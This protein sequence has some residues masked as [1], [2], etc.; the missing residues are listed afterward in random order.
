[1]PAS[2]RE[3]EETWTCTGRNLLKD[4]DLT[5]EEFIYLI[6]LA[7]KLRLEK[8]VGERARQARGPEHRADLREGLDADAVGVRGRRPR[9]G[10]ARHLPRAR[11][12]PARSQGVRARTPPACSAGCSTGSSTAGFA[13]ESV[14]ILGRVAG[15]PVWNGLT[16][17]WHPTQMLADVL[18]M[19]DHSSEAARA[20]LPT[21]T[22]ATRRNNTAN[23]L[24]VTG[25][26]AGHGRPDRRP[27]G[28]AGRRRRSGDIAD[29]LWPPSPAR[30]SRSP[31]TSTRPCAAPTSST[32]T[33][34]SP[35]ASPPAEWDERIDLLLPYQVNAA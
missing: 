17:Q 6:D 22:W 8:H 14:E 26:L 11:G 4:I 21:A 27:R 32:P 5:K 28:A 24:L 18:T 20:T 31:T 25:A 29:G 23:S 9:R 15:V 10:G 16:D 19:R 7:A 35:W 30:G 12:V 1:M 33:C 13:Q 2:A 3:T 34:G